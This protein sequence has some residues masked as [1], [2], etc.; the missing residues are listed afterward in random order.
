MTIEVPIKQGRKRVLRR[1][2]DGIWR[3]GRCAYASKYDF[4]LLNLDLKRTILSELAEVLGAFA[5]YI[6][7]PE[8]ST[9]L[10]D[11][12]YNVRWKRSSFASLGCR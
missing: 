12:E 4:F 7:R 9:K 6:T 5:V 1:C 2:S 3:V 10:L 11:F 8:N